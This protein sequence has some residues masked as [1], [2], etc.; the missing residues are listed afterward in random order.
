M[1]DKMNA[2]RLLHSKRSHFRTWAI[3]LIAI[4]FLSHAQTFASQKDEVATAQQ[5]KQKISGTITDK[6][7]DPIPGVAVII[8]GTSIGIVTDFDGKYTIEAEN[9]NVLLF[10]FIGM[11][12][13]EV[14]V[15]GQSELNITLADN[16]EQIDE[17]VV[18]ALSIE[19]NKES[20]GYSITQ[21]GADEINKAKENNVMNSLAGK[22]A[23]LQ[24]STTPSGVDGST[25]IVLRGI[26]SI[27]GSNRPL[28]VIDGIPVDG[29]TFGGAGTDD[30]DNKDMGDAL[31]DI[32]PEDVESMSVL[33]GAGASAAYGS[34]GANG[35]ILITTKK[36]T[37]RDGIGVSISSNY[38]IT[39]AYLF[40]DMQNVYGQGAFGEYPSSIL[41]VKGEEPYIWSWGPK[42]EGQTV[43]NYLG[44]EVPFV[45]QSNPYKDFYN[46]G[47]SL[48]TSVAFEGGNNETS[49]RAS[50]TNQNSKGI[51]PNNKMSKQTLNLRGF[52]KLGKAIDLDGK[53]TYIRLNSENRPYLAEDNTSPGFAFNNMPRSVRV[54]D[55]KENL[56][57]EE[58]NM[59]WVWDRT[60]GNPYWGLENKQ[61]FD[62]RDRVQ[63]HL[64]AK[65]YI[66]ENLTLLTRSG[67][68]FINRTARE[69]TA[70]GN[71]EVE[72]GKGKY[73]QGIENKI[74]WNTDAL[75]T[76][77]TDLSDEIGMDLNIG[78]NYRY[79]ENNHIRHGGSDWRVPGF[80][81]MSNLKKY[82]TSEGLGKKEVWSAF[83]LGQISWQNYLYF[84]FTL[85]ND[86][87]STLP[88]DENSYFYHSENLSFLFTEMFN[89][90]SDVLTSGKLRASY[91][92]VGNDTGPYK[93]YNYYGVSQS[94][95]AYSTGTMGGTLSN[96]Y[97][98]PEETYSWEVGT[99][100]GF[101]NNRLEFDL[102]YYDAYTINQIM[103]VKTALT[104]GW[105]NRWIN[106]GELSNK[107]FELQINGTP[108]ANPKGLRWDITFNLSKNIS[109]VVSLY[110]GDNVTIENLELKTS[111]M[112][113]AS[114]RANVGG[115]FG[116]I[117]GFDYERDANG[118]IM[119]DNSGFGLAKF[120]RDEDGEI[121]YQL[122]DGGNILTDNE[123]NPV[124]QK[125]D[126]VLLGDI[127]PDFMGGLSN[128]FSYKNFSLS[129]LVDFQIGGE[130][131]SH[132]ALYRDLF[133]TGATSLEGREEWDATHGGFG[134]LEIIPGV[135]P[136]GYI[137]DGLN[138][139]SGTENTIPVQPIFRHV[140]TMVN[141]GIVTDYIMDATNV[142]MREL[143]IGYSLPK[144][145]LEKTFIT[146]ANFSL[147]G[148]N[149]FFLYLA[150]DNIDPEVGFDGGN[151][152]NAFELN[153]MPGTRNF[154]FNL[155][156][157]F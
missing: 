40:P 24:I 36:G 126:K 7:G 85:R 122:D 94:Q 89:I 128:S 118:N 131:Y 8:K 62:T 41:A 108:I 10:S 42:M 157:S 23:G 103:E 63:S 87:S 143:V 21:I 56:Y 137:Q 76:Y 146:K 82:G 79:N 133:G 45:P 81:R 155:N 14:T 139:Y 12:G 60:A 30:G 113:W 27:K 135:F 38:Q 134:H 99:N 47:S 55:L 29:G 15:Q 97:L 34:R 71:S 101:W 156:L 106:A 73:R 2:T 149:L 141:R 115:A 119:V 93:L 125:G 54:Q 50:V 61:N 11:E 64:S 90:K 142:R 83:G 58:G 147:V 124:P 25:R 39:Q 153:T 57:N 3:A 33:K 46:N 152:G 28:I 145:W 107:G 37:K 26:S 140:E 13:Q 120:A 121:I 1:K 88:L 132:S 31:S 44:Q 111:V 77:K 4:I 138:Y 80:Y 84:D 75:L 110:K 91:A 123:G 129:F 9:G 148:R 98:K 104:T 74:E 130:Y 16:M 70:R 6:T 66:L 151:F 20:L 136:D 154:G 114:V 22:V 127:N 17:V 19:R 18:T 72:N 102:T 86:W 100:L 52:T 59:L 43:T 109:E 105:E 5:Q 116:E 92:K 69:Y 32:N 144:K 48:T 117:F 68:D 112:Q 96:A 150:T 95:L 67:F 35:V 65:F 49:F 78:G 53:I 51:V